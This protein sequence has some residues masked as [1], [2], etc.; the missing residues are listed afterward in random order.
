MGRL[1][2]VGVLV[3]LAAVFWKSISEF[4]RGVTQ[5]RAARKPPN[6]TGYA[7]ERKTDQVKRRV[8]KVSVPGEDREAILDFVTTRSGVEAYMEPRTLTYPLSVVLVALDGEWKRFQLADDAFIR[9]LTSSH[10][11]QVFDAAKVGYPERMRRYKR[12]GEGPTG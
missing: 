12:G 10:G 8:K 9:S 2:V 1:I 4:A 3:I 5:R 6:P 7:W 11:M